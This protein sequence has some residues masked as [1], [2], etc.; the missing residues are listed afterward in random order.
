MIFLCARHLLA[1][2][3]SHPSALTSGGKHVAAWCEPTLHI[4]GIDMASTLQHG[5]NRHCLTKAYVW[6]VCKGPVRRSMVCSST[7]HLWRTKKHADD[8]N[9]TILMR[10]SHEYFATAGWNRYCKY[11]V[12]NTKDEDLYVGEQ[13]LTAGCDRCC[14]LLFYGSGKGASVGERHRVA[15]SHA[16]CL[17]LPLRRWSAPFL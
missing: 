3:L 7:A 11:T 1:F 16:S 6:H 13:P 2:L 12:A 9:K 14:R 5:V 17:G 8:K 4:C 15:S 10:Q